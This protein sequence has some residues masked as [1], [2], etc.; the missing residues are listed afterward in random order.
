MYDRMKLSSMI[1]E[2]LSERKENLELTECVVGVG[3][4]SKN[5]FSRMNFSSL[6]CV[7]EISHGFNL[8]VILISRSTIFQ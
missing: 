8:R 6:I 7:Y 1:V 3:R 4:T 2:R 5:L